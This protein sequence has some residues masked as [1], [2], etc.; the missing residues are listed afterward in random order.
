MGYLFMIAPCI[1]CG[2]PFSFNPNRVPSI[3]HNGRR[4]PL[5]KSCHAR[6]N[7]IRKSHGLEPWA[8]PLPGAY[9]AADENEIIWGDD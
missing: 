2:Q 8:D 1:L 3:M 5:C 9:E 7:E 6:A 4:E